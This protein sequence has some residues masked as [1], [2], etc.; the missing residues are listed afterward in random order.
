MTTPRMTGAFDHQDVG[1][2][3]IG[4]GMLRGSYRLSF[5]N[6]TGKIVTIYRSSDWVRRALRLGDLKPITEETRCRTS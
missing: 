3:T 2:V 1:R 4:S 6:R 5:T